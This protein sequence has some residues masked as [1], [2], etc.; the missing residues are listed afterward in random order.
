MPPVR[1]S[2]FLTGDSSVPC[3]AGICLNLLPVKKER[4]L[5]LLVA[6]Q[7]RL[8]I[9]QFLDVPGSA[10]FFLRP[11]QKIPNLNSVFSADGFKINSNSI[12]YKECSL[13]FCLITR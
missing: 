4:S 6:H 13:L 2:A 5:C 3:K 7:V 10:T 11:L 1:N 8:K 12:D 9:C